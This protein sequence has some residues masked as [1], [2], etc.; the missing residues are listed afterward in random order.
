[1]TRKTALVFRVLITACTWWAASPLCAQTAANPGG[2]SAGFFAGVARPSDEAFRQIYGSTLF[3]VSVQANV[4]LYRG[5]HAFA[6]YAYVS[7]SGQVMPVG[8]GTA[9]ESEPL[10]FRM[11]TVKAGGLYAVPVWKLTLLAGA[12][13]GFNYYLEKWEAAGASTSGSKAGLLVQAGA[14]VP[15]FGRLS[16]AGRIEYCQVPIRENSAAEFDTNLG[17]LDFELG[18]VFRLR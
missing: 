10:K 3:P 15:V 4:R 2:I 5:L 13:V 6:G 11:H 17:R 12:G 16:L 8:P 18:L 7:R 1:M 9:N 14:E